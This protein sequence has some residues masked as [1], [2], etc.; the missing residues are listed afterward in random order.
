M[1]AGLDATYVRRST[2]TSGHGR[3][4]IKIKTC[5]PKYLAYTTTDKKLYRLLAREWTTLD[6]GY[7]LSRDAVFFIFFSGNH[8][9]FLEP[10]IGLMMMVV[11]V[12]LLFSQS[13]ATAARDETNGVALTVNNK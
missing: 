3:R 12:G 5:P 8:S 7:G 1:H 6:H 4:E 2:R 11:V 9:V 13:A 10:R